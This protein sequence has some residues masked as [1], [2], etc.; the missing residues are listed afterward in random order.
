MKAHMTLIF[1]V[2][3]GA[4][5]SKQTILS[6]KTYLLP[7][8]VDSQ[9]TQAKI[10]SLHAKLSTLSDIYDTLTACLI[11][12]EDEDTMVTTY[13]VDEALPTDSVTT[14]ETGT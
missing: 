2:F 13:A 10:C 11:S 1:R 3:G 9:S 12:Q 8:Q 6:M 5:F 4:S 14:M 7:L